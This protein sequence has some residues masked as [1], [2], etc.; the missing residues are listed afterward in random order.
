MGLY[1]RVSS[2]QHPLA[3]DVFRP[4]ARGPHRTVAGPPLPPEGLVG[5]PC[6][7]NRSAQNP[8]ES[9][10]IEVLRNGPTRVRGMKAAGQRGRQRRH[11]D[12]RSVG[13]SGTRT[14]L[15]APSNIMTLDLGTDVDDQPPTS[16]TEVPGFTHGYYEGTTE[17]GDEVAFIHVRGAAPNQ[18]E[19]DLENN[20][21]GDPAVIWNSGAELRLLG[22]RGRR[23]VT[24]IPPGFDARRCVARRRQLPPFTGGI[25]PVVRPQRALA[26]GRRR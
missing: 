24:S 8:T 15:R 20:S 9:L 19:S 14:A 16:P 12:G 5:V 6:G 11:E 17:Q 23:R 21:R 4:F 22:E 25:A 18:P 2:L 13:A 3:R 1:Q 7:T 10:R 26:S